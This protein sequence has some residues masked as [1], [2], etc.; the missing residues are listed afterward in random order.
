MDKALTSTSSPSIFVKSLNFFNLVSG[1]VNIMTGPSS[2]ASVMVPSKIPVTIPLNSISSHSGFSV[3]KSYRPLDSSEP[4]IISSVL[5][6]LC[7]SSIMSC[8]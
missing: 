7:K 5:P 8:S 1:F 2:V 4:W 6:A 3:V